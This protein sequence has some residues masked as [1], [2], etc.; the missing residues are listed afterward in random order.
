MNQCKCAVFKEIYKEYT[1]T[2][3]KNDQN[4]DVFLRTPR[5]FHVLMTIFDWLH[6]ITVKIVN[7]II[8]FTGLSGLLQSIMEEITWTIVLT[9]R[10]QQVRSGHIWS[11]TI[12]LL[13]GG[14]KGYVLSPLLYSLITNNCRHLHGF[15]ISCWTWTWHLHL[16]GPV[17]V[18]QGLQPVQKPQRHLFFLR[19]LIQQVTETQLPTN[20]NVQR[21]HWLSPARSILK[22]SSHPDQQFALLQGLL[23]PPDQ[24]QD[25]DQSHFPT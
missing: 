11:S 6:R 24:D 23:E 19:T 9:S 4:Q 18:H 8:R 2:K 16:K 7:I 10:P 14:P 21:K 3:D 15:Q 1:H 22:V 5:S 12:P 17:L 25:Q 20:E 13:T